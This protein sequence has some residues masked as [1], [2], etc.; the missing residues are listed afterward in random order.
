MK[1]LSKIIALV[2]CLITL[3]SACSFLFIS[4]SAVDAPKFALEET[5]KNGNT[6][7][8][9][10]KLKSGGFNSL[11]CRFAVS[12]G[13]TCT[14]IKF[15]EGVTGGVSNPKTCKISY[16]NTET[17]SKAGTIATA[18]FTVPSGNY[19]ITLDVENCAISSGSGLTDV[20]SSVSI[21]GASQSWFAR[22]IAA[23]VSFFQMII[24]FFKG[25]FA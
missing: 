6:V 15:A 12:S 14:A 7:T 11:D 18:T 4:A 9:E 13:V 10:L 23:I 21:E 20:T 1:K 2:M 25:L 24:N 3:M 19:S 8:Y 16:A 17:F 22:L 5:S